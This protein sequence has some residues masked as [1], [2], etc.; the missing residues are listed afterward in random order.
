MSIF[1]HSA[2][3]LQEIKHQIWQKLHFLICVFYQG[4]CRNSDLLRPSKYFKYLDWKCTFNFLL[5][6]QNLRYLLM[7]T[8]PTV[9]ISLKTS[10]NLDLVDC[11][12]E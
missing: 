1:N 9:G 11:D 5:Y 2:D 7:V 8:E 12:K 6:F 10:Q 4:I 3:I